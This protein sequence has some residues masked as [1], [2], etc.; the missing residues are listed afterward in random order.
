[1]DLWAAKREQKRDAVRPLALR[2]RPRSLEEYAG[3]EHIL[4]P[5]KLLRRMLAADAITSLIFH[6]RLGRERRRSR[7]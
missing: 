5:G 6:G 7:N 1:M 4:G 2:M 3:Q